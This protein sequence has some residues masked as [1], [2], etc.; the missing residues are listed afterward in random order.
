MNEAADKKGLFHKTRPQYPEIFPG[1]QTLTMGERT[2]HI[3]L[4]VAE[5]KIDFY[6]CFV[7]IVLYTV[8]CNR[9]ACG[10]MLQYVSNFSALHWQQ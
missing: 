4:F 8:Y 3:F 1:K 6:M 9:F 7:C 5:G 10:I 2:S